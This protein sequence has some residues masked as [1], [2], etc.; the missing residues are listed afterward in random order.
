MNDQLVLSVFPG[1]DLLGRA[2]EELGFCV[3]RGPDLIFGGDIRRFTPPADVFGGVIGGSPC[4]DFSTARRSPPTGYGLE[5]IAEFNR[6]IVQ[7]VPSWWLL[8]NVRTV[9]DVK[10]DGYSWQRVD[11]RASEWGATHQ[12][13]RH[14]QFGSR[15]RALIN[16]SRSF[17]AGVYD[18]TPLATD[19]SRAGRR[20]WPDFVQLQGLPRD[21]DLPDFNVRG[22]YKA[23]GNG[24][25]LQMGRV[26]AQ[27]VI[28]REI[29]TDGGS[30]CICGCGRLVKNGALH[31]N[32]TCRKRM[33]ARRERD[34]LMRD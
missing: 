24:V 12:R 23:V 32:A 17:T 11:R 19:G 13:L 8:E 14:F 4:Q 34:V 28:D 21:Y 22:K 33:Q 30:R 1:I 15:E 16:P 6:V 29:P 9:P 26:I 18:R 20:S 31:G 10:I 3:V 5:M 27:A 2:F 7:A 25:P